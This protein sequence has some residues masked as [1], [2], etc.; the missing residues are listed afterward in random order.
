MIEGKQR[1]SAVLDGEFDKALHVSPFMD[2]DHR[3]DARAAMPD[4]ML[5]VHIASSRAGVTVL[6]RAGAGTAGR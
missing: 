4:Q 1:D 6:D 3:Y 5:S 2:M